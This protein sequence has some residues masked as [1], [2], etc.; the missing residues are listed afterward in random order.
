MKRALCLILLAVFV[1]SLAG[2]AFACGS[3]QPSGTT[4]TTSQTTTGSSTTPSNPNEIRI[5]NDAGFTPATLTV[6]VG[7]KVTWLNK[8][9]R[10]VWVT[11]DSKVPDTG[12]IAVGF[13]AGYTFDKAGTYL[14]YEA[15]HHDNT[16]TIIVQ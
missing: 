16:G 7:T 4:T 5:T 11:S 8:T 2:V 15:A 3:T 13:S 12:L 10:R 14:Y 6:P 9:T 1:L